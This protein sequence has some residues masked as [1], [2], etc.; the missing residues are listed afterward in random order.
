[1]VFYLKGLV[2]LVIFIGGATVYEL[3]L[4]RVRRS[5]AGAARQL[6]LASV[7]GGAMGS[8]VVVL[9]GWLYRAER[10]LQ[11]ADIAMLAALVFAIGAGGLALVLSIARGL[12]KRE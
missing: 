4:R 6:L 10:G 8:L 11:A 9:V 3:F 5:K 2:S 1:M 7:G 12:R